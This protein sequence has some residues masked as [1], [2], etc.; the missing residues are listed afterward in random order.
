MVSFIRNGDS[1][2]DPTFITP[3]SLIHFLTGVISMLNAN[4]FNIDKEF[5]FSILLL[6]HTLY[7]LKDFYFSYVYKGPKNSVSEWANS[8]SLLNM[9]SDTIFFILGTIVVFNEKLNK[10]LLI[11]ANV[12]YVVIFMIFFLNKDLK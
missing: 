10:Q 9:T 6:V 8:N 11:I 1:Q 12:C 3:W 7:E 5:S 2:G 4:Y